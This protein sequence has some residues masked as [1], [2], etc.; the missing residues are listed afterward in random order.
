MAREAQRSLSG[1]IDGLLNEHR[2]LHGWAAQRVGKQEVDEPHVVGTELGRS[3]GG[4]KEKRARTNNIAIAEG[5]ICREL[6]S[7]QGQGR[8]CLKVT[9]TR[10]STSCKK[11]QACAPR[12]AFVSTIVAARELCETQVLRQC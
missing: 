10:R 4:S 9:P 5:R 7:V 12:I 3:G 1:Q 11:H 8:S 6:A 2:C